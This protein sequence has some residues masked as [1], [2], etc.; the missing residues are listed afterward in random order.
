MFE[1]DFYLLNGQLLINKFHYIDY[2]RI[3]KTAETYDGKI[4]S[5]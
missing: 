2:Y 4:Y 5:I 3:N 1:S